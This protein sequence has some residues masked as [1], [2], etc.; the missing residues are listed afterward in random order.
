[1]VAT[2]LMRTV[3][4]G[5]WSISPEEGFMRRTCLVWGLVILALIGSNA[6]VMA[7]GS[8]WWAFDSVIEEVQDRGTLRVGLGLFEPWSMCDTE[9][10]LIGFDLDMM[11]KLA[12]DL[13]VAV[14]W[15]P[16][17][18]TY[19]IPSLLAEE[20]DVITGMSIVPTRSLS[21]NFTV[22][23]NHS[24]VFLIAH[25]ERTTGMETLADFNQATVLL[26]TRRGFSS[27]GFLENVFP[28]A[29]IVL[30]ETDTAVFQ[31]VA[32]GEVHAAAA[33]ATTRDTW[34]QASPETLYLPF[35]EPFASAVDAL[36][37]R[38]GDLDTLNVLNS[39][40]AAHEANGWL[41]QRRQY[42]FE[43]REWADQV[44]TDP[45]TVAACEES[46]Q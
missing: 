38:K 29:Q 13:E 44:A 42:W 30:F 20:F 39:W 21:V 28:A 11:R 43:T 32:S 23:Y 2:A 25:R 27:I 19:I 8:P 40:I 26:A 4:I 24:G 14:E 37:V 36:A 10:E 16:S 41:T 18:W 34:V 35:A 9:G 17:N 22:P 33:F 7:H 12:D 46:F 5:I 3:R 1:M 31:A 6:R 45:D 15:V